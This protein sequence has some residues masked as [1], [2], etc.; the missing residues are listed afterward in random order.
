MELAS[1]LSA[2]E[3]ERPARSVPSW[4]ADPNIGPRGRRGNRRAS[5]RPDH[6][7]AL[8][9]S[10]AVRSVYTAFVFQSPKVSR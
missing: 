4:R 9:E 1:F 3:A 2:A 8:S 5:R 10:G 7:R 6:L